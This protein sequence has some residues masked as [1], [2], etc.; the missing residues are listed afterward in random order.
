MVDIM[1]QI[2]GDQLVQLG[3][4]DD[5]PTPNTLKNKIL[6]KVKYTPPLANPTDELTLT[7]TASSVSSDSEEKDNKK[8]KEK[9]PSKI[10]EALSQL[11]VYT[12]SYHF[13]SLT[14]PSA[15]TPHHVFSLSESSLTVVHKEDP[16]AL[17]AHNEKYLIRTYPKGIRI[18][19]SNLDPSSYWRMGTQLVALNWQSVD[20]GIQLNEGMFS[21][22]G[23]WVLKPQGLNAPTGKKSWLHIKFL[24]GQNLPLP[25]DTDDLK[26]YVKV[27]VHVAGGSGPSKEERKARGSEN[28]LKRKTGTAKGRAP[29]WDDK[30]GQCLFDSLP[31]IVTA[32]SFVR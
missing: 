13:R 32:V 28:A 6:V 9:K 3:K 10:I 26:P 17:L 2:F 8:D 29:R 14:D 22:T 19:S 15:T 27:E 24:G 1:Q 31:G 30:T 18:R 16:V 11:G 25:A 4:D 20:K 23:G 12:R 7:R 5:Q 21:G